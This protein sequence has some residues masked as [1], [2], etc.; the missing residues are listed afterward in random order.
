LEKRGFTLVELLAVIAIIGILIGLFMPAVQAAR[1][2]SR[3][4]QCKNKLRQLGVA[5]HHYHGSYDG[6]P[7]GCSDVAGD[8]IHTQAWGW[9]ALLL[10]FLEQEGLYDA[11]QPAQNSLRAAL[12][13]PQLQPLLSTRLDVV[14]CPSDVAEDLTHE[15]R[16]LTGFVVSGSSMPS[17]LTAWHPV[18]PPGG[19]PGGGTGVFGVGTA[20]SNYVGSFGDFWQPASGSWSRD[21]LKGNGVFGSQ[22]QVRL[23]D[24]TDGS[25]HTFAAGERTWHNYA[26]AWSGSDGWDRCDSQGIPMVLGT[27][28]YRMN[29]GP[30]PYNL[31][32]D[33]LGAAGFS[34]MHQQGAQFLLADGAV[35]FIGESISFQN[36]SN[37]AN[38]GTYQRLARRNDGQPV[39]F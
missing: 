35:R 4:T 18:P 10:P 38:L 24:L 21:E 17:S 23:R 39:G 16:L 3:R 11:L 29:I 31:S 2:S 25:S 9:I 6:F 26:A 34:S 30:Q 14:R 32:C 8:P 12:D 1:E 27:A 20:T 5:L 33:G 28:F 22:S 19:G 15:Y 7:A 36:A 13:D 37:P